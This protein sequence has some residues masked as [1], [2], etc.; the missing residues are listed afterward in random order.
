VRQLPPVADTR[1]ELVSSAAEVLPAADLLVVA[2]AWPEYR[3]VRA[4]DVV[5][6][7]RVPR[8]IDEARFLAETL[9][10]DSRVQYVA[11]GTRQTL[12]GASQP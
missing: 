3:E 2:T 9:G 6:T 4:Q 7:M 10:S 5:A 1:I 12:R 8:V 11:V